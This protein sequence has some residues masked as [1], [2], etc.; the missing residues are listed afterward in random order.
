MNSNSYKIMQIPR[1]MGW[2]TAV[3]QRHGD[4]YDSPDDYVSKITVLIFGMNNIY[5]S[6]GENGRKTP[7]KENERTK[8]DENLHG[9]SKS[10]GLGHSDMHHSFAHVPKGLEAKEMPGTIM[11]CQHYTSIWKRD[12]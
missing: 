12:Q 2:N 6:S 3:P 9:A 1:G 4:G 11:Y 8:R 5:K 10:F 7:I